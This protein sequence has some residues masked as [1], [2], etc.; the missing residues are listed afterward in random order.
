MNGFTQLL[1]TIYKATVRP[2][3][4]YPLETRAETKTKQILE[5]NDMKLL[6]EILGKKIK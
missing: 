6:R 3:M 5:V 1:N 4:T 2:I